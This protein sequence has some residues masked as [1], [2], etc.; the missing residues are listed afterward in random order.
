MD[1]LTVEDKDRLQQELAQSFTKRKIITQRIAEAREMGDLS[2]NAEYHA[3]REDQGMNE[4]KIRQ[5]EHRLST[6]VVAEAGSVPEDVVFVGMTVK[7]RDTK[8]GEE[9]L[10]RLVGE[11][12]G[13]FDVDYLEVTPN[14]PMGMALMK[15]KVGETV[16]VDSRRGEKRYEIMEIVDAAGG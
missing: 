12:S 7:L 11:T 1:Y 2:E 10:C 5:I 14:S 8:S 4:A 9:E 3:A 16:R 15:A 13:R 6:A